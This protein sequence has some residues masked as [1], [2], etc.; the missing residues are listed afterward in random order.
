MT[1]VDGNPSLVQFL[2]WKIGKVLSRRERIKAATKE[3]AQ[4]GQ[5]FIA[6]VRVV[7]HM[8]GLSSLTI[9]GFSWSITAGWVAACLSCFVL[10][11]LV[12][13]TDQTGQ[14]D[15]RAT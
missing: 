1:T 3:G 12:A 7:L 15:R 13:P 5:W 8:A 4:A 2:H 14:S 11:W 6:F 9:A 10:S